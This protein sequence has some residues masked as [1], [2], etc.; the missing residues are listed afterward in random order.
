[1]AEQKYYL[2][3]YLEG[4]SSPKISPIMADV[5]KDFRLQCI[6]NAAN[7]GI[8]YTFTWRD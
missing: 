5:S 2:V 8:I 3:I 1:M 4:L 6:R 7:R